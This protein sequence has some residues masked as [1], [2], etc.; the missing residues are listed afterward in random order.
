MSGDG[1][2]QPLVA[3]LYSVPLLCEAISSALD[4]IAEVRTFR[5]LRGDT[6]GLLRSITP[7]AVVVDDPIEAAR[8]RRWTESRGIPL[9]HISLRERKISVLRGGEWEESSGASAASI[10][11]VIAGSVFARGAMA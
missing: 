5:A 7:D 2:R 8:A 3:V 11:N 10:R 9:V 6:V 4:D 1:A